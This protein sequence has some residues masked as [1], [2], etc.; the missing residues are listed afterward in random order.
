MTLQPFSSLVV[1]RRKQN[2]RISG[3]K[4]FKS[5]KNSLPRNRQEANSDYKQTPCCR[6]GRCCKQRSCSWML[7]SVERATDE[8]PVPKCRINNSFIGLFAFEIDFVTIKLFG[9]KSVV[10][11]I[12]TPK[13]MCQTHWFLPI[14]FTIFHTHTHFTLHT[15][16]I[17]CIQRLTDI[18]TPRVLQSHLIRLSLAVCTWSCWWH[19]CC[20]R[21]CV[22]FFFSSF[23]YFFLSLHWFYYHQFL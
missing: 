2:R 3:E 22:F 5:T 23:V 7:C 17:V 8:N 10:V 11:K 21:C 16:P 19:C 18:T 4:K 1:G 20:W 9:I 14:E 15:S 13:S 6:F 12:P